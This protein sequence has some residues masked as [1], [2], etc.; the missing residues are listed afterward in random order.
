MARFGL[1]FEGEK[2]DEF[3]EEDEEGESGVEWIT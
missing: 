3:V 1:G 2:E